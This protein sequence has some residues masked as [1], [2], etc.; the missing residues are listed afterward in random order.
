MR[1]GQLC[2][3]TPVGTLI[4]IGGDFGILLDS[5]APVPLVVKSDDQVLVKSKY[6]CTRIL[7]PQGI[8]IVWANAYVGFVLE[9]E[10]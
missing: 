2:P 9:D 4:L 5:P 7:T 1:W 10:S 3:E 8:R 6:H